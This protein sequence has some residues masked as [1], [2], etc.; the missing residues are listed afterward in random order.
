VNA[1]GSRWTANGVH[2]GDER[3]AA[4]IDG[5]LSSRER[6]SIVAHLASCEDC[7]EV[8]SETVSVQT[9]AAEEDEAIVTPPFWPAKRA[10]WRQ[11]VVWRRWMPAAALAAA[12]A[13]TILV[14]APWERS[15][16]PSELP[17][18]ALA[19]T[20][21]G[22]D[23]AATVGQGIDAHGFP[24]TL[25]PESFGTAEATAFS[26]G[27]RVVELEVAL[28]AGDR[29]RG[30][31]LTYRIESLLQNVELGEVVG[32]TYYVG[33]GGLRD[34]LGEQ[35][36]TGALLDLHREADT[37]LAAPSDAGQSFVDPF[38]YAFGKWAEA[39]YLAAVTGRDDHFRSPAHER[40]R[41]QL[42]RVDLPDS[43]GQALD[44]I[45]VL[46]QTGESGTRLA[47]G[48]AVLIRRSGGG[49]L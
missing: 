21:I 41:R 7:Y 30:K 44:E 31:V 29:D 43:I 3:L 33:P 40:F 34:L 42:E 1:N 5:R 8:F 15:S 20:V 27:V 24:Q 22:A 49:D 47:D 12:A 23:T 17:V 10:L 46:L 32:H 6:E 48:F 13:V 26:L 9:E 35:V 18:Q 4:F 16:T 38:W 36:P 2:P 19:S 39:G 45:E 14:M 25:G 11:P 37:I 28:T